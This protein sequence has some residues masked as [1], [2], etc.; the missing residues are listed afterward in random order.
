M[1]MAE[2]VMLIVETRGRLWLTVSLSRPRAG[3]AYHHRALEPMALNQV[4]HWGVGSSTC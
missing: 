1:E 2:V 4:Q 3:P